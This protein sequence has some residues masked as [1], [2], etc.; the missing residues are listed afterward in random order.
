MA[1]F[2]IADKQNGQYELALAANTVLTVA[3]TKSQQAVAINDITVMVHSGDSP[4][5]AKIGNTVTVKDP[6]A[7]IIVAG[8]WASVPSWTAG[9]LSLIS[10]S[11]AVVSVYRR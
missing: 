9:T 2:T 5:Y 4:V 8:Q 1:D 3:V 7:T 10:A 11:N 6:E